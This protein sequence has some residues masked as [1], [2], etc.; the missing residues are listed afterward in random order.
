MEGRGKRTQT[1]PSTHT[2][3][4]PNVGL[5]GE[6]ANSATELPRKKAEFSSAAGR[7]LPAPPGAA[8]ER[9]GGGAVSN[10]PPFLRPNVSRVGRG[11]GHPNETPARARAL[12]WAG[13]VW[14]G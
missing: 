2:R 6:V 13:L 10:R 14:A 8:E 4:G 5:V 3:P 12:R 1:H 7:G 11:P 9:A